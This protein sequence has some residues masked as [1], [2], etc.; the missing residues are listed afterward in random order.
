MKSKEAVNGQEAIEI[1]QAWHPQLIWMDLQ[2]PFLNG[3]DATRLI[4][5]QDPN[6]PVIIALTAQALE[7]DE[8]QALEAGCDGYLRKPYEAAQIFEKMA[9][10]LGLTYR[11][12]T[13]SPPT[14]MT[15]AA[16]LIP[17]Q[18]APDARPLGTAPL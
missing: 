17:D 15:E 14:S 5:A 9:Q 4:K 16:A 6:P 2:L 3:L 8:L 7:S 11:Y 10:H 1:N 18:L 12:E 13:L